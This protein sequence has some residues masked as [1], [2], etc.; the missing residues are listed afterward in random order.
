MRNEKAVKHLNI[1]QEKQSEEDKDVT[2]SSKCDMAD[3]WTEQ[4]QGP[5]DGGIHTDEFH[6]LLPINNVRSK[7]VQF[8]FRQYEPNVPVEM[9]AVEAEWEDSGARS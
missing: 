6:Y 1:V 3:D 9:N 7:V 4:N 2:V 8:R 5:D